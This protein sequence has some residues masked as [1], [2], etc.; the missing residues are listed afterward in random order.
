MG[1]RLHNILW[2]YI[3]QQHSNFYAV[4]NIHTNT[5]IMFIQIPAHYYFVTSLTQNSHNNFI[6]KWLSENINNNETWCWTIFW[7][8]EKD[9]IIEDF[10]FLKKNILTIL[11][12]TE[13]WKLELGKL[14][15]KHTISSMW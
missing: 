2:K 7:R 6:I 10:L 4:L 12:S 3:S 5:D 9:N 1:S 11:Q 14:G 15:R 13:I 8:M